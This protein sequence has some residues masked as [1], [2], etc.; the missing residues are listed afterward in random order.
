MHLRNL[1]FC[2]FNLATIIGFAVTAMSQEDSNQPV[3]EA[4]AD[5]QVS[6]DVPGKGTYVE[7]EL[8]GVWQ[9]EAAERARLNALVEATERAR[10][11]AAAEKASAAAAV[12]QAQDLV[13]K[14][15]LEQELEQ[16]NAQSDETDTASSKLQDAQ[17]DHDALRYLLAVRQTREL[18]EARRLALARDLQG[19]RALNWWIVNAV[20]NQSAV[21]EYWIG[22]QCEPAAE[23]G[24]LVA[25]LD[26]PV[27]VKGGLTVNAVTENS[28]AK[29]AGVQENDVILYMNNKPTN[30]IEDL[31][32]AIAENKDQS[33]TLSLVR[34]QRVTTLSITPAKRQA[35]TGEL[36]VPHT[37]LSPAVSA[38]SPKEFEAKIKYSPNASPEFTIE[39]DGKKW[40]VTVETIGELPEGLRPFAQSVVLS[41]G[42]I[43]HGSALSP[44]AFLRYRLGV[45]PEYTPGTHSFV[46][47]T[48]TDPHRLLRFYHVLPKDPNK[49][50]SKLDHLQ[51]QL[52][53][54]KSQIEKLEK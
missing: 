2:V 43:T 7:S 41:L 47:T 37:S 4:E 9:Q 51:T 20:R 10:D 38:E 27:N 48:G 15:A 33:A 32:A 52:D 3:R 40:I 23:T 24:V 42:S 17:R 54:L 34:D 31:V 19:N 8:I 25:G 53:E 26:Q 50:E 39:Q 22:V 16:E 21:S 46:P 12:Q 36:N 18:D 1:T 28:P 6:S 35:D 11:V 14:I 44:D 5:Q 30:Q 49:I 13:K 45:I 29:A